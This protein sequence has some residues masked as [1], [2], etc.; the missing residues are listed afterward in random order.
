MVKSVILIGILAAASLAI[1]MATA[2]GGEPAP[3][4]EGE[5]PVEVVTPFV[6][7]HEMQRIDG[8][9]QKLSAYKGKVVLMVNTASRCGLTPQ[10]KGLEELYR[11]YKDRG[12]VILGFPANNFGNQEPGTN[13]QIAEFCEENFGV[14]FP[15]FAKI[16]V[17]GE[18]IHPLFRQLS[19]Q[20]E[21]I[22]G[23]PKWNF[24]KFLVDHEGKVVA[25]FEPRTQPSDRRMLDT[26]ESLL[27]AMPRTDAQEVS[28]D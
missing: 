26:I 22:G 19:R 18:D 6:L 13:E 2:P 7:G 12:L 5:A 16:S 25:R 28:G 11:K 10:Y 24:T 9:K 4:I 20:P 21:P 3:A 23:E 14:S 8:T 15:M 27:A 1:A 17:T